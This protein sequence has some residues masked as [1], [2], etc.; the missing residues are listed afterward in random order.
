MGKSLSFNEMRLLVQLE[1]ALENR[2]SVKWY[3]TAKHMWTV[4]G[5]SKYPIHSETKR[6][7][8]F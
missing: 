6:F 7:I 1:R 3:S 5:L 8:V 4:Q 2:F